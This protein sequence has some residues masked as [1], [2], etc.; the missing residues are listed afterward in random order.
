MLLDSMDSTSAS[1][2]IQRAEEALLTLRHR[3]AAHA[4][5]QSR[6]RQFYWD[7]QQNW[8][9]RTEHLR[10]QMNELEARIAP[11]LPREQSPRLSVLTPL[12]EAA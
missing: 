8:Q 11:W 1:S 5:Q 4:N 10:G 9:H 12:D 2:E 6:L 7:W 3:V